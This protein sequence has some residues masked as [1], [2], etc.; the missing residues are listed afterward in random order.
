MSAKT[1]AT[2]TERKDGKLLAYGVVEN[3]TIFKGSTVIADGTSRYAQTNDGTVI[4]LTAGDVFLGVCVETVV[5]SG[6][7]GDAYARVYRD[8]VHLFTFSDT[9]TQADMV[10]PVYINNVSDDGVVTVTSDSGNPEVQI[11]VIVEVVGSNQARVQISGAVD[12]VAANA[13]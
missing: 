9:L 8:G 4:T 1:A 2:E 13:A 12:N 6:S 5:N 10:K 3:G 7:S 11:G